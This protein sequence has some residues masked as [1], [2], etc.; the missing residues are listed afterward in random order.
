MTQGDY[1][2]IYRFHNHDYSFTVLICADFERF[3]PETLVN[4]YGIDLVNVVSVNDKK[5]TDKRYYLK[6][7]ALAQ[8]RGSIAFTYTNVSRVSLDGKEHIECGH[9]NVFSEQYHE[10]KDNGDEKKEKLEVDW[11]EHFTE[12]LK[13]DLIRIV[14]LDL[15]GGTRVG[16]PIDYAPIFKEI[17][18]IRLD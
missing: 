17:D 8:S 5:P 6:F 3:I 7:T 11:C 16:T 9:S 12:N 4:K 18:L 15:K 13:G 14:E 2:N 1:L 10:K